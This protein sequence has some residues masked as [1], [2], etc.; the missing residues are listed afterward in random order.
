MYI[1]KP[2]M[3]SAVMVTLDACGD[4]GGGDEGLSG[5]GDFE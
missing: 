4:G 2:V 3:F 5:T 1:V